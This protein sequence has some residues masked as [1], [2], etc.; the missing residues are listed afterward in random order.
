MKNSFILAIALFIS[1]FEVA[2]APATLD[3][4]QIAAIAVAANEVDI[5][6]AKLAESKSSNRE[7][8]AFA[9][10][11]IADH[12]GVIKEATALVTKLKVTP[13]ENVV[14]K[15][16]RSD[17]QKNLDRLSKLDGKLFNKAYIQDEIVF[18]K[19]VLNLIDEKLLPSAKNEEL[20]ALLVKVRAAVAS[21]LEHA[22]KIQPV[23]DEMRDPG[24]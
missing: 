15:S 10:R 17:G 14:S 24:K 4:A 9:H 23:V 20:Q 19:Q 22:E 13:E 6:A 8:K 2:A 18:H 12:S 7:V 1:T 21:H 5:N 16:V 3:D 11:M